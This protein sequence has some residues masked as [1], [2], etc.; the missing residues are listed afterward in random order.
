MSQAS[1]STPRN[2]RTV[3]NATNLT[4]QRNIRGI[5]LTYSQVDQQLARNPN[6]P[7]FMNGTITKAQ[8]CHALL[9]LPGNDPHHII[10]AEEDHK[11]GNKHFH[12]YLQWLVPHPPVG[13]LYFD[14]FGMH[15]R[16][17]QIENQDWWVGYIQ[18]KDVEPYRWVP[19]IY[20]GDSDD[21]GYDSPPPSP[22][23]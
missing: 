21:E 6:L 20:I 22:R 1:T 4:F 10:V 16:V 17:D 9:Q 15:P 18:K 12:C 5:G 13:P 19:I 3:P 23:E 7:S 14:V 8:L 11:D 2:P